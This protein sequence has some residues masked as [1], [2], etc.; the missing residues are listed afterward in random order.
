ML[1]SW[2]IKEVERAEERPEFVYKN[3]QKF[4][5]ENVVSGRGAVFKEGT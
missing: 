3:S 5:R 4:I 2:L 1:N